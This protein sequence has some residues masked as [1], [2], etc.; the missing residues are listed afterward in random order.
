[1]PD[2]PRYGEGFYAWT[3]HQAAV[4]REMAAGDNRLDREH[5]AEASEDW[6]NSERNAVP[7]HIRSII[8]HLPK[9]AYA[10]ATPRFGRIE[11]V[12][13]RGRMWRTG[14]LSPRAAM[15]KPISASSMPMRA[16]APKPPC[17]NKADRPQ[18]LGCRR[19]ARVLVDA[20]YDRTSCPER[21]GAA[22]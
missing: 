1:M 12:R 19:H 5:L 4:L 13:G 15:L 16:S 2:R 18:R 8:E 20:I 22:R 17:A 9:L 10:P 21:P 14:S 11:T 7:S 3:R 6:G